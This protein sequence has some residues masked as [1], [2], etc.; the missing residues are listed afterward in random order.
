MR[1][2]INDIIRHA[3][4]EC[5]QDGKI[6]N[7]AYPNDLSFTQGSDGRIDIDLRDGEFVDSVA[8]TAANRIENHIKSEQAKQ[9]KQVI[10][11]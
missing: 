6:D 10:H 11:D 5:W 7:E 3:M 1:K 2:K 8:S 9:A 4:L